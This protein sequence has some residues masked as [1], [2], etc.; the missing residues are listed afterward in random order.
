VHDFA[1]DQRIETDF[2]GLV[3]DLLQADFLIAAVNFIEHLKENWQV[4]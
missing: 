2:L 4:V 3:V 1:A